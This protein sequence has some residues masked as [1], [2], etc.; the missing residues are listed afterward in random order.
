[1]A[2]NYSHVIG[3]FYVLLAVFFGLYVLY[4]VITWW[5]QRNK[6]NQDDK[7]PPAPKA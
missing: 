6:E 5:V 3:N 4:G 2:E 1:M 7:N